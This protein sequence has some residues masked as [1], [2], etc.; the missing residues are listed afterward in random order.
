MQKGTLLVVSLM[1]SVLLSGCIVVPH[2]HHNYGQ[3]VREVRRVE[4]IQDRD[5]RDAMKLRHQPQRN[6]GHRD[7]RDDSYGPHWSYR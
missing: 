3:Q 7:E 5:H 1:A 2:D 6:N 4:R